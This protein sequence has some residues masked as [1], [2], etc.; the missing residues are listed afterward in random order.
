M[1]PELVTA[2]VGAVF[3]AGGLTAWLRSRDERRLLRA[4]VSKTEAEEDSI[5]VAASQRAVGVVD[6][7]IARLEIELAGAFGEI[8]ALRNDL[9]L[10][11][12]KRSE[13]AELLEAERT[14]ARDLEAR[15]EVLESFIRSTG[16]TPP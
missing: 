15:V 8:A 1:S 16:A 7:A 12:E 9:A 5:L 6:H 13:L 11:K 14:R 3:G 10:Q 4:Q 2:I